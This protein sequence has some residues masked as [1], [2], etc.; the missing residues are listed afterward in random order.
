M[1]VHLDGKR[2]LG[3]LRALL[4]THLNGDIIVRGCVFVIFCGRSMLSILDESSS[5]LKGATTMPDAKPSPTLEL[6]ADLIIGQKLQPVTAAERYRMTAESAYFYAEKRGF[7]G[8]DMVTDW[9]QAE[10]EIGRLLQ[11]QEHAGPVVLPEKQAYLEKLEASYRDW[12]SKH[13]A[14]KIRASEASIAKAEIR[15]EIEAL[16]GKR[17]EFEIIMKDLRQH[18]GDTWQD[19]KLMAENAWKEMQEAFHR[20]VARMK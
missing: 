14:L 20:I 6:D 19:L 18:T 8:G 11:Q 5:H 1:S 13:E 4:A 17:A 16:A 3:P 10:A 9:V 12:D 2:Q 15:E 7:V